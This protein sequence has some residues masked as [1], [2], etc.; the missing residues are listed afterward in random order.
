MLERFAVFMFVSFVALPAAAQESTSGRYNIAPSDYGFVR[1]DTATGRT[2][3]CAKR[4]DGWYCEPVSEVGEAVEATVEA[5]GH[6][7]S[8]LDARIDVLADDVA[9]LGRQNRARAVAE[10]PAQPTSVPAP[11]AG[12]FAVRVM[13]RF[14][15]MVR[16]LKLGGES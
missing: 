15:S 16:D 1:M 9:E 12:G 3:H 10:A 13:E 4:D 11:A 5:L 2:S 6:A 8:A 14:V 7:L